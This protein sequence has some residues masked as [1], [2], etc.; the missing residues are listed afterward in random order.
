M[1]GST[2]PS[3]IERI[4]LSGAVTRCLQRPVGVGGILGALMCRVPPLAAEGSSYQRAKEL[5]LCMKRGEWIVGT[6]P[7]PL[8]VTLKK[9]DLRP[10]EGGQ[11]RVSVSEAPVGLSREDLLAVL[12]PRGCCGCDRATLNAKRQICRLSE[13]N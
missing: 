6:K 2:D 3:G 7:E 8:P 13:R 5:A 10:R 11:G 1:G 4:V 9:R 12:R